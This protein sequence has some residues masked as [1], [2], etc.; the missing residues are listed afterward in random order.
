MPFLLVKHNY[1]EIIFKL[2]QRYISHVK[3]K[4][5]WNWN[6]ITSAAT[7]VSKLF[8]KLFQR[9]WTCLKI[10]VSCNKPVK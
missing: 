9:Q 6:K 8:Q 4:N 2:F 3:S 5:V 10:F 1:F 7:R